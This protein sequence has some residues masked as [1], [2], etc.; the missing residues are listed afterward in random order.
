MNEIKNI[1]VIGAGVMGSGIAAHIANAGHR[2]LLFDIVPNTNSEGLCSA[3]DRSIIA[4][5]AIKKLLKTNPEPFTHKRNAKRIVALNIDDH[6]SQISECDWII[7]AIVENIALKQALYTRIEA[8]RKPGSIV[9]SN[10][11]TILLSTLVKGMPPRF[12]EDFCIT[13]FFNPPRYMRLM[14]I[15]KGEHTKNSV[16]DAVNQFC[17]YRLGKSV[18]SCKDSPGFIA[19]RLGVFWIY[20]ALVEAFDSGISVEEADIILAKP[21]GVPKTGVFALMDLVGLDLLPNVIDSMLA[22]LPADDAF[23]AI[24]RELP[25]LLKMIDQGYTGRKGKGGF[26]RVKTVQGAKVKEVIDL[27]TGHYAPVKRVDIAGSKINVNNIKQLFELEDK[28]SSYAWRVMSRTLAYATQ[29]VPQVADDINAV[30][31]AMRLGYNWKLGPF[32]LIDKIGARWFKEKLQAENI[33]ISATLE[34]AVAQGFYKKDEAQILS[35]NTQ[36]G[37]SSVQRAAGVVM[38][39]DIKRNAQAILSNPS[40]SLWDIGD[41]VVCFEFTSKMNSLDSDTMK[42]L[43][44]SILE[45]SSNYQAMVIYSDADNFSAGANLGLA[46]FAANIA[47]WPEIASI[48]QA[49]QQAY[50]ALKYSPFP[51]VSAPC[52]MALGG[53]CEILLHSD[54]IQA[55]IET[56]SGL[57]EAGV[58]LVPAWGGCKE[59]LHRWMN[60]PHYT[61][62][63]IAGPAKAF[64]LIS[65]ATVSKSAEQA[66]SNKVMRPSDT[67]TMNRYRLLADAKQKALS[68]VEHYKAP[69]EPSF[70]LPGP[71]AKA[72][73]DMT[74]ASYVRSAKATKHDGVVALE[75]AEILSGGPKADPQVTQSEDEILAL[76]RTS[77]MR[78]IRHPDSLDRVEHILLTGKPLRN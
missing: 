49:G 69:S 67:I 25:L 15:V 48:V 54:A 66:K 31:E 44:K 13:H 45:V 12:T 46:M 52:G 59:M 33:A 58:G 16:I 40:A 4:K 7:E 37:Y 42:L 41:G 18:V 1:C 9:S 50:K 35:L 6:L 3:Q 53:G 14:E 22:A 55:H 47:A 38:L 78:I 74:I 61:K 76:E 28:A 71:S 72:V 2:V 11:S 77:F 32:E 24:K 29:L 36:G 23:V 60:D 56:Y 8:L 62:G 34:A 39:S 26:Y 43:H 73:F 63:P 70:N 20:S 51:V 21:C 64:E 19:N 10:T 5:S 57:V 17:D 27:H 30:D 68:L 75:I 65:M